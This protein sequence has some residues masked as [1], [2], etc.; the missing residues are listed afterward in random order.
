MPLKLF[1]NFKVKAHYEAYQAYNEDENAANYKK[2]N[3]K[4]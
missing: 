2:N 4:K 3:K 1:L